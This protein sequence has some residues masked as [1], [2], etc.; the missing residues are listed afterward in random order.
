MC[1]IISYNVYQWHSPKASDRLG[2]C[3][4]VAGGGR[5]SIRDARA[6]PL[7]GIALPKP[8]PFMRAKII[9]VLCYVVGLRTGE[10]GI[11]GGEVEE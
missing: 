4:A 3:P 10:G 2:R 11:Y 8:Y 1:H 6:N 5:F 7:R 9:V